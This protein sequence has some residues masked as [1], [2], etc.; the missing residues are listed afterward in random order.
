MCGGI[1]SRAPTLC[2]PIRHETLQ[3]LAWNEDLARETLRRVVRDMEDRFSADRYWPLH[4]RDVEGDED[5]DHVATTLYYGACGVIWAL[6]YLQ[7]VRAA[8][9]ARGYLDGLD[10]LATRNRAWLNSA[11]SADFVSFLMGD[12]PIELLAYGDGPDEERAGRLAALI[13]G[14][15][16]SPARELMWGSPGTLLAALFMHERTGDAGWAD[17]FRQ[18][19]AGSGRSRC[20]RPNT[21]ATTGP[22]RCMA[23]SPPT[24]TQCTVITPA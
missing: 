22:R 2:D 18:T 13:A 4:P 10:R 23:C 17:L 21:A 9:L 3:P 16:E 1:R 12:T 5:P 8:T 20:G 19:A 15:V 11:G 24:S 7:A 14:N 6:Q